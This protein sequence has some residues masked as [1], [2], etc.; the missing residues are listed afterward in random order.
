MGLGCVR[1]MIFNGEPFVAAGWV[2]SQCLVVHHNNRN[3]FVR[4]HESS[5]IVF[6]PVM[7][8]R[9]S[10]SF[11]LSNDE[12]V[13]APSDEDYE[14]NVFS[15]PS[16]FGGS[17]PVLLA[18]SQLA[19]KALE[20]RR[21]R[22][23][24]PASQMQPPPHRN[25]YSRPSSSAGSYTNQPRSPFDVRSR[26]CSDPQFR[27]TPTPP[28]ARSPPMSEGLEALVQAA[29][30]ERRR[31]SS[32]YEQPSRSPERAYV[33]HSPER[34]HLAYSPERPPV[35]HSP[36]RVH[37]SH[38]PERAYGA[39]SP[40]RAYTT[41]TTYAPEIS[42]SMLS[43]PGYNPEFMSSQF[44]AH[45]NPDPP[46][47]EHLDRSSFM[48]ISHI[49][50]DYHP[51][52]EAVHASPPPLIT[53]TTTENNEPELQPKAPSPVAPAMHRPEAHA[54][55]R[56][57]QIEII[58]VRQ[59]SMSSAS[60]HLHQPPSPTPD[61]D[62]PSKQD[63][64]M[65]LDLE[66]DLAVRSESGFDMDV[67]NEL[68]RLV[69]DNPAADNRPRDSHRRSFSTPT[70]ENFFDE[71]EESVPPATGLTFVHE[72]IS[73]ASG[74]KTPKASKAPRKK[75]TAAKV[76]GETPCLSWVLTLF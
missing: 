11:L 62:E 24:A 60:S 70:T 1:L 52:T 18:S 69:D 55:G 27:Q 8:G 6:F 29:T 34:P 15:R 58:D 65:T 53:D 19:A 5:R 44:R 63:D 17:P 42:Y 66:F 67:D 9:L 36:E 39:H 46:P 22:E 45:A 31:L 74:S 2:L 37:T 21:D 57:L 23:H 25:A 49:S 13:P 71:K 12:P 47:Q 43:G 64:D 48:K 3:L 59:H 32:D 4:Y 7:A 56:P 20:S 50:S 26:S 30:Q 68:L 54:Q 73:E 40:E 14:V 28:I 16:V 72:F 61:V 35:A 76:R 10:I 51:P 41:S 75:Q 38:S 33:T